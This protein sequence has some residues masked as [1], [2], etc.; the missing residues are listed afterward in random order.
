[1]KDNIVS[2]LDTPQDSHR[3]LN[4]V[5]PYHFRRDLEKKQIQVVPRIK[6]YGLVFYKRVIDVATR[7]SY[8][9]GYER[10]GTKSTFC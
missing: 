6:Q 3:T 8:P 10:I 5:T 9:Y 4:I 1:M 7:S 2:E